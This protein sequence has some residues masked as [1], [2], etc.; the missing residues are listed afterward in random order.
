M[1]RLGVLLVIAFILLTGAA[2]AQNVIKVEREF[3]PS[4]AGFAQNK[5]IVIMKEGTQGFQRQS[6]RGGVGIPQ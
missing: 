4:F 3:G 2:F 5:F 6:E 1:K